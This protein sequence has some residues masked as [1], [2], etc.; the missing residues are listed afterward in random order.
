MAARNGSALR[1]AGR[2]IV[3]RLGSVQF[4]RLRQTTR[5]YADQ[6]RP[7]GSIKMNGAVVGVAHAEP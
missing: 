7:D 3:D 1:A 2:S 5:R 6:D 4:R